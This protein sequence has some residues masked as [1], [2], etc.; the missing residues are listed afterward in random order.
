MYKHF[1]MTISSSP[2]GAGPVPNRR[3]R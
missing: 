1:S 3:S 2:Q